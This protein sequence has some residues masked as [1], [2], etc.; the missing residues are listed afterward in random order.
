MSG[1]PQGS[2]LA[3]LLFV[4]AVDLSISMSSTIRTFADDICYYK[5]IFC[6]LDLIAAQTDI[7]MVIS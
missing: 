3:P 2:I 4:L 1:V 7:Q 6:N 5:A